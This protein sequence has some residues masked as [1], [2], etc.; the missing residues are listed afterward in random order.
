MTRTVP[1]SWTTKVIHLSPTCPPLVPHLSRPPI[2]PHLSSTCL[3]IRFPLIS[4]SF[5]T[6]FPLISHSF[7]ICIPL[8]SHSFPS[9]FPLVSHSFS[10]LFP[11]DRYVLS[12][13]DIR[14]TR[15]RGAALNSRI[16][17][18]SFTLYFLRFR[19]ISSKP[20]PD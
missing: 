13:S 14:S 1:A 15:A 10:T 17:S 18:S 3:P 4:H 6:R 20:V 12:T 5:S 19:L 9:L 16:L 2:F 8:V 7:P 11:L